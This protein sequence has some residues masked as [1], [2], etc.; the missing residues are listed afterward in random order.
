MFEQKYE[1]YQNFYL[2]TFSFWWWNFRYIWIGSF[3]NGLRIRAVWLEFLLGTFSISKDAKFIHEDNEDWSDRAVPISLRIRAFIRI[4]NGSFFENSSCKT[5]SCGQQ[6]LIRLR[7][8]AGWF[9]FVWRACPMVRFVTLRF[10]YYEFYMVLASAMTCVYIFRR[11]FCYA[12]Y[13]FVDM[14]LSRVL[15]KTNILWFS[16]PK[17]VIFAKTSK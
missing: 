10:K 15:N 7:G 14:K 2:K 12:K 9:V 5:Y 17:F 8:N 1:K 4:F 6:R 11:E 3:Y 13:V 16:R